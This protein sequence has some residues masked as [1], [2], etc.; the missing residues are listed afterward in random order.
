MWQKHRGS[1]N[2]F[3]KCDRH[4]R[5]RFCTIIL[6]VKKSVVG[7]VCIT[8][9]S[10]IH[11][12]LEHTVIHHT[13]NHSVYGKASEW[14]HSQNMGPVGRGGRLLSPSL[15]MCPPHLWPYCTAYMRWLLLAFVA[16]LKIRRLLGGMSERDSTC[17]SWCKTPPLPK[18]LLLSRRD[19]HE[20]KLPWK[21]T[22]KFFAFLFWI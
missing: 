15:R 17:I 14:G 22:K 20:Y 5:C 6:Q 9:R 11:T 10:T 8:T 4:L 2:G 1:S 12:D 16:S 21:Y 18:S 19:N 3:Q 13:W 7:D